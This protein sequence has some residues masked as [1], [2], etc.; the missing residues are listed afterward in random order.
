MRTPMT[1]RNV[2]GMLAGALGAAVESNRVQANEPSPAAACYW[3]V[4]RSRCDGGKTQ[5]LWCYRCC[6][7]TGCEDVYREWRP[8]GDC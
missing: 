2:L 3:Y 6:D 7:H 4:K 1:R 8:A 5:E